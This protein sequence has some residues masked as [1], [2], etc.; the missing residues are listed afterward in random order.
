MAT[1]FQ[2]ATPITP[3]LS[4]RYTKKFLTFFALRRKKLCH[5]V[6]LNTDK[7]FSIL[8]VIWIMSQSS[9]KRFLWEVIHR[10]NRN[11]SLVWMFRTSLISPRGFLQHTGLN[12]QPYMIQSL[13]TSLPSSLLH[14][15]LPRSFC[16][17]NMPSVILFQG[18][19]ICCSL[20]WR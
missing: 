5:K 9:G 19:C 20:Y 8:G 12:S 14:L 7:Q 11:P 13:P 6:R 16:S 10:K 2:I 17:Q 4:N 1:W 15:T 18:L 3:S